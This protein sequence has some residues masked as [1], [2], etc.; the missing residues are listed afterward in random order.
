M[1][2][3]NDCIGG[4]TL[5]EVLMTYMEAYILIATSKAGVSGYGQTFFSCINKPPK[6]T[7]SGGIG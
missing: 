3:G 4:R 2:I 6:T 5:S 7:H 1:A